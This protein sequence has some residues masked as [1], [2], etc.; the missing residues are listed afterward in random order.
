LSAHHKPSF[1]RLRETARCQ[2]KNVA[3]EFSITIPRQ[4]AFDAGADGDH[5]ASAGTC[6]F[7]AYQR[8]GRRSV[9]HAPDQHRSANSQDHLRHCHSLNRYL[10]DPAS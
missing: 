8:D 6:W 9:Q 10:V 2:A 4:V 7:Y 5:I 1:Y 3:A